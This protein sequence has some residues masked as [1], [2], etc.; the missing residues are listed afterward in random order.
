[1]NA[2]NAT[3]EQRTEEWFTAR[4]GKVTA[5]KINDVLATLKSGGEAATR[6]NYKAQLVCERLTGQRA[7]SYTNSAMQW[8]TDTEPFARAAYEALT[9]DMV[10]EAGFIDH[11]TIK[12]SGMSPD[13]LVGDKGMI[14]IKC[15]N[16]ATMLEWVIAD[17]VPAE[18]MNQM[19]WQMECAGRDWCDF[20]A[21]DP[22]LPADLQLFVKRF[23]KDE[24]KLAEIRHGV[25]KFL[26]E[27]EV[28][29]AKLNNR[30]ESK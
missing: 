23:H 21:F 3:I 30:K 26:G 6:K 14:E 2:I 20:V 27:I 12:M 9:G 11:P 13:G 18:H 1:M 10:T 29:I 22:R 15:P 24:K 19:L 4:L 25:V 17:V 8:G 16:T 5:S 7:E 28:M